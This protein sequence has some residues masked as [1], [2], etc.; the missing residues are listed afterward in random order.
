MFGKLGYDHNRSR[1]SDGRLS[2]FARDPEITYWNEAT[3]MNGMYFIT[4]F[5][6]LNQEVPMLMVTSESD[7]TKLV[8]AYEAGAN[9]FLNK[10]VESA[11][12]REA[13]AAF[14]L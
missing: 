6:K 3:G 13:I 7:E 2:K 4:Q 9:G 12:L 10:P 5:R 11:A 1:R 14:T 8:S